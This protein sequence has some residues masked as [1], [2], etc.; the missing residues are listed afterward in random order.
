MG[1]KVLSIGIQSICNSKI[2]LSVN[3]YWYNA[4]GIYFQI[5][6]I[7]LVFWFFS[8]F[9]QL[10]IIKRISFQMYFYIML[11]WRFNLKLHSIA[12]SGSRNL[13]RLFLCLSPWLLAHKDDIQFSVRVSKNKT[14]ETS[15]DCSKILWCSADCIKQDLILLTSGRY[16]GVYC[17]R[18]GSILYSSTTIS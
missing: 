12:A 2:Q 6:T 4:V 11:I 5:I 10:N 3:W 15:G 17:L 13:F 7:I 9:K 1:S 18:F 8:F 14:T 16:F